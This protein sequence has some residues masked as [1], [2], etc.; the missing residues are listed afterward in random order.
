LFKNNA[1]TLNNVVKD[2]A[3]RRGDPVGSQ[4]C[5]HGCLNV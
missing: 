5:K 3:I 4:R 1:V 2:A